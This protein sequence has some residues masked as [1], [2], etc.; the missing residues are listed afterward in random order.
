MKK[1]LLTGSSGY[2]GRHIKLYADKN[3][4]KIYDSN[5]KI[6]NLE[7]IHNLKIYNKVKFD[8][9][10]HCATK[11]KAGN[12]SQNHKGE[13]WLHNQLINTN[14]LHYWKDFQ[15]QAK[16]IAI[17]SSC[18][19]SQKYK[20]LEKNNLKG[21]V[22]KELYT[23][24]MTKRM[25]LLGLINFS[26]EY[27][28]K[29]LFFVPSVLYGPNYEMDDNH[30]IF[31]FIKKIYFSKKTNKKTIFYGSGR[32]RR[33]IIYIKD[34]VNIIFKSLRY[35]D[36]I[37]NLASGREYSI[38][39]YAYMIAD[40]LKYNRKKIIFSGKKNNSVNSRKLNISKLKKYI[41]FEK[42][43]LS[44]GLVKTVNYFKNLN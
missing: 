19:Y 12:Y 24:G 44:E 8:Y 11:A 18:M 1:I 36:Q 40:L 31:D 21:D 35:K 22:E 30:F 16:M 34:A 33:D 5:S 4:F 13:Q 15:P 37:F 10:F 17:G 23:Y 3:R 2:L 27:N 7:N 32:E 14:I 41:K 39:E 20:M 29:Y 26:K 6:G 42:T 43:K 9:I 38:K 28:L 25:L